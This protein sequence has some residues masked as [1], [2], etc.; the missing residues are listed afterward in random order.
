MVPVAAFAEGSGCGDGARAGV[1]FHSSY[2]SQSAIA[3]C[4]LGS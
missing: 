3:G 4:G 2:R 1:S